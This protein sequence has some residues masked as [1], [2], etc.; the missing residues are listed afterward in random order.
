MLRANVWLYGLEKPLQLTLWLLSALL[1]NPPYGNG[2]ILN[3]VHI[4]DC[5]VLSQQSHKN[6]R[7]W[8]TLLH[9]QY[10]TICLPCCKQLTIHSCCQ[11]KGD[12]KKFAALP[13][14]SCYLAIYHLCEPLAHAGGNTSCNSKREKYHQTQQLISTMTS[15]HALTAG[16]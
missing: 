8:I 16:D 15:H 3:K 13:P 5:K 1:A 2:T 7:C 14:F 9:R 12:L 11:I 6:R 4:E 10:C